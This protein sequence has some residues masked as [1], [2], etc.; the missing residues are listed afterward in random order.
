[1]KD[2]IYSSIILKELE[3]KFPAKNE[4]DWAGR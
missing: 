3:K 1:M 4:L 2:I